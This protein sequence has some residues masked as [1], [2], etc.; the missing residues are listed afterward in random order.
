MRGENCCGE[1]S[2][3]I[4]AKYESST[5]E[6]ELLGEVCLT[7]RRVEDPVVFGGGREKP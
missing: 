2:N 3:I 4:L 5:V 1:S 7:D 6:V